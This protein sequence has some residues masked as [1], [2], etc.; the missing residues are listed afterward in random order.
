VRAGR[1]PTD[2]AL[3]SNKASC[4][5]R[6][7]AARGVAHSR[8]G[9]GIS[10]ILAIDEVPSNREALCRWLTETIEFPNRGLAS[11][12]NPHE[13]RYQPMI[14]ILPFVP[15]RS[16]PN[17]RRAID[18]PAWARV[19]EIVTWVVPQTWGRTP[20]DRAREKLARRV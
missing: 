11:V 12:M 15:L 16:L 13:H 18:I 2:P 5:V 19:N 7:A 17:L 10:S 9:S 6:A 4:V 3:T 1:E 14:V 8:A 20:K